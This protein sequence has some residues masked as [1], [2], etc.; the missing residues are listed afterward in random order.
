MP[1]KV[2]ILDQEPTSIGR[3]CLQRREIA[4]DPENPILEVTLNGEFLMSSL[5]TLSERELARRALAM[6]GGTGL[7]VLVGGLG[8]GYTA[9]EA[10][11]SDRTGEV[12]VVEFLPTVIGWLR[13]GL[14]PLSGV[15]NEAPGFKVVE[16][17]VYALLEGP[18]GRRF[19]LI[20][21]DVDHSPEEAL[22]AERRA[23]YT[24]EGLRRARGHLRP[25][26][27]LAVWS[28]CQSP[29]FADALGEVF[30]EVQVEPVIFKNKLVDTVQADILYLVRDRS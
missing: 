23:F 14:L 27:V 26:G 24:A 8:L 1:A 21:I 10:L 16:G 7:R 6:H 18:P 25:G 22:V 20:L 17:D 9:R 30:G 29:E 4:S 13:R 15:L 19:D 3:L 28:Y 5:N 2:T 11:A 12:E